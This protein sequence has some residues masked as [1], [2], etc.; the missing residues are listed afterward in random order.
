MPHSPATHYTLTAPASPELLAPAGGPEPFYAA[1]A[2]GADAI[3]CGMGE[4]NARRKA[5]NFT[6]ETFAA[7][8]TCAHIA[9]TRVYVTVNIVIKDIEMPSALELIRRCAQLG[10][11]AFIIQDWGLFFEVKRL[12]PQLETHIS[13]QANIHD[14]RGAAWCRSVGAD[15]VTLSREL[16]LEEISEIS[17]VDIDL[18]IFSHGAICFC[19]SGLCE[20]SSFACA[21]RSANRGMCAQ[22][23]R[24]PYTLLDENGR[25]VPTPGRERALCP[26]DNCMVDYLPQLLSAGAGALKLEGRMK[27]PDYVYSIC[28]A[29]RAQLDDVLAART[30]SRSALEA[31]HRATRG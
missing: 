5:H 3:Y 19:Y 29:Y 12:M 13:T 1:V 28:S 27:A 18:E 7:A 2:A 10:A 23:C 30:P 31:R 11:D 20:L 4:F 15:R 9:G 16:S 17:A 24:L 26:R 6:D 14:R 21:G 8:C 22:P 25:A